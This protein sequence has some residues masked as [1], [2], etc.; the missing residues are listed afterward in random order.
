MLLP[1][2]VAFGRFLGGL[3]R[4]LRHRLDADEPYATTASK[5]LA[6]HVTKPERERSRIARG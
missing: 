6:L 3:R 2:L 1:E 5:I 4:F